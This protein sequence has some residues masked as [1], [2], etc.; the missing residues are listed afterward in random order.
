MPR[1]SADLQDRV[2]TIIATLDR[3]MATC[4][5]DLADALGEDATALYRE[6]RALRWD[7]GRTMVDP[8]T[9]EER[10]S[11][12]RGYRRECLPVEENQSDINQRL[13]RKAA[14]E[15]IQTI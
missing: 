6:C 2:S 3:A 8:T 5:G 10:F 7:H 4:W 12:W 15:G 13:A 14:E 1:S 11:F 9:L